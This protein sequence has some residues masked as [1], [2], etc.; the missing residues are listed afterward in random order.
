M[1]GI[2]DRHR[3]DPSRLWL[4]RIFGMAETVFGWCEDCC[5]GPC[6]AYCIGSYPAT[7]NLAITGT[8]GL[9]DGNWN[10][11]SLVSDCP[12]VWRLDAGGSPAKT[13][14]VDLGMLVAFSYGGSLALEWANVIFAP[15]IPYDCSDVA[16][17]CPIIYSNS[18]EHD[19]G[20][21]AV[22]THA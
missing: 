13:F 9:C 22:I 6:P 10:G 8:Y 16:C 3:R 17:T 1:A 19:P 5:G 14:V 7:L 4:P 20:S 15:P 21:T 18:W 2:L 12:P 11:L